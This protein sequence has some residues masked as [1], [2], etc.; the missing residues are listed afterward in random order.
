MV[1][2]N[3]SSIE[4]GALLPNTQYNKATSN[5]N[6]TDDYEATAYIEFGPTNSVAVDLCINATE[7]HTASG[8]D[9]IGRDNYT[10]TN[11]TNDNVPPDPLDGINATEE[12]PEALVKYNTGLSSSDRVYHR[13]WLDVP[14]Q[15]AAGDYENNVTFKGVAEGISCE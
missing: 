1:A 9:I 5:W 7:L 15:Q 2:N 3:M 13:F 6:A 4:F 12:I 11:S 8:L 14:V 10:F